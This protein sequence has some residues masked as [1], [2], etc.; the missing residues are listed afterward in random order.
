MKKLNIS[1][2][3]DDRIGY[4]FGNQGD[5]LD[6]GF[7]KFI[8]KLPDGCPISVTVQ[9]NGDWEFEVELPEGTE[10]VGKTYD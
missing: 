4:D 7:A 2:G 3:S 6:A 10:L 8:L 9:Y 5:C 1:V